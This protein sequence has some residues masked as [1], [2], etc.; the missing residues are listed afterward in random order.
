MRCWYVY[1]KD[2]YL[3]EFVHA[4]TRAKAIYVSD[5]YRD[6]LDWVTIRAVRVPKLDGKEINE[7]N[8]TAAGF[9]WG[10]EW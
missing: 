1:Y 6:T 5:V 8:V 10:E 7:E 3:G 9:T 2:E 4:E